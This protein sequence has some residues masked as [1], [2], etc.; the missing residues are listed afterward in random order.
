LHVPEGQM[1][2]VSFAGDVAA[3]AEHA[4]GLLLPGME[5]GVVALYQRCPHLG[6]RV[7]KGPPCVPAP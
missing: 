1:Y 4:D 7:P 2:L 5:A 6:C 3:A